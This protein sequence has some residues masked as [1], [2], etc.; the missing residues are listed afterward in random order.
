MTR[1]QL[2]HL[3]DLHLGAQPPELLRETFP[4]LAERLANARNRFWDRLA[5]WLETPEC[6]VGLVL[7]A[8]DLFDHHS[9]PPDVTEPVVHALAR[10]CARG[11]PVVTVPGNHDEYSYPKVIYRQRQWPGRLV[12]HWAVEEVLHLPPG[13]LFSRP[14]RI[15]SACFRVGHNSPGQLVELPHAPQDSFNVLLL[16]GTVA[17]PGLLSPELVESERCFR[18]SLAEAAR[19]GYHYIALGHI[20]RFRQWTLPGAVAV[21]PGPPLGPSPNDPGSGQLVLVGEA[22]P[23]SPENSVPRATVSPIAPVEI[24]DCRWSVLKFEITPLDK[25]EDLVARIR[26]RVPEGNEIILSAI[27]AGQS[28][29][30]SFLADAQNLL[31]QERLPVLL[32]GEKVHPIPSVDIGLLARE[33]SLLGEWVRQWQE[34]QQKENPDPQFAQLVLWEALTSFRY[35]EG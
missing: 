32:L 9:P 4:H 2:L 3:A 12:P 8:G 27:V 17:D 23:E 29:S 5:K 31:I 24:L 35:Q 13:Q 34:W 33:Q 18:I 7:V 28:A 20:H 14:L 6:P 26:P 30:Q 1:N 11:I 10:I 22:D 25:P 21:Y 16:H 19:Q 15:F